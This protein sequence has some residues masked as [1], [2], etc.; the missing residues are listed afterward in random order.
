[1]R[2]PITDASILFYPVLYFYHE[3]DAGWNALKRAA[4]GIN[5]AANVEGAS[6]K[7]NLAGQYQ[8]LLT[9]VLL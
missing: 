1:M 3:I 4:M 2:E 7:A 5:V 6:G 9:H 8:S